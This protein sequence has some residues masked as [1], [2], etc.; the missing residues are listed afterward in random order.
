MPAIATRRLRIHGL[1][2]AGC[3]A[4]AIGWAGCGGPSQEMQLPD[5]GRQFVDRRKIDVKQRPR[6][7]QS[8]T[9]RSKSFSGKP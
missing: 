9:G 7:P 8:G 1:L 2:V 4:F 3:A 6:Q 5:Q